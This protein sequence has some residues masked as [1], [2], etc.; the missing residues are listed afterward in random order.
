MARTFQHPELFTGLT[1]R[2]HVLLGYRARHAKRRVWSD[3]FTMGSLRP[4][5]P[6]ERAQV[7]ELVELLGLS[8]VADRRPSGC[9]WVL[10]D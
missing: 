1:V 7:D 5:D 9:R 4:V 2:E 6:E 3:L 10:P 8:S